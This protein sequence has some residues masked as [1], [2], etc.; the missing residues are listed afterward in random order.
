MS[1]L[2]IG[3]CNLCGETKE[4]TYEHVPPK[5]A[6]NKYKFIIVS[7]DEYWDGLQ[8]GHEIDRQP[9]QGGHGVYSLCEQCNNDTGSWYGRAFIDWCKMGLD[10]Y[11]KSDGKGSDCYFTNIRPLRIIKQI[12][13]MFLALHWNQPI[14][15]ELNM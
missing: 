9:T 2:P 12:T 1:D 15:R 7:P 6:F 5:G 14:F 8:N 4:L 3:M 13:T 10:F 11:D